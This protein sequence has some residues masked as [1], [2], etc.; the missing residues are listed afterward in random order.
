M[1][2]NNVT[3]DMVLPSGDAI[4]L[5]VDELYRSPDGKRA[6]TCYVVHKADYPET[7]II[8]GLPFYNKYLIKHEYGPDPKV[9]F[10]RKAGRYSRLSS[11]SVNSDG[12]CIS[13]PGGVP[14]PPPPS[15]PSTSSDA[16][17]MQ[18]FNNRSI[19]ALLNIALVLVVFT[20]QG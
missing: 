1:C 15:S 10:A 5:G 2:K 18:R 9:C 4:S 7:L 14:V 8:A 16:A 12:V 19:A 17:A 20:V 6:P 13:Q 3:F 11:S